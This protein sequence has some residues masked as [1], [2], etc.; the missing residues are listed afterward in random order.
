[1]NNSPLGRR[2]FLKLLGGALGL[3]G[4]SYYLGLNSRFEPP[5]PNP[6]P[7]YLDAGLAFPAFRGPYLQQEARLTALLFEADPSALDTL[8]AQT[9]NAVSNAPF[10]YRPILSGVLLV[11]AEM[12]VGSLDERDA[13][14]GLIPEREAGFWM[15]TV[16]MQKTALGPVPHHLAWHIPYLLVDES[17]AIATGREVY[18]FNKQAATFTPNSSSQTPGVSVEVLGFERFGPTAIAQKEHLLTV[19][20][21]GLAAR[22]SDWANWSEAQAE[23]RNALPARLRNDLED[24]LLAFAAQAALQ[25][26][27]LVFLKQFRDAGQTRQAC[28][29]QVVEA[30]IELRTFRGGGFFDQPAGMTLRGL[31]SHPLAR[32]LGLQASQTSTLGAWLDVDFVLGAGTTESAP[33]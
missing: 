21:P 20:L 26:I 30:P 12:L 24:G 9:V 3:G 10:E 28:F 17:N 22:G 29:Q 18:G 5:A 2:S 14:V 4:L 1:M 25:D 11:Y 15:L 27:P 16:A 19:T 8:C 31:D 23:V 7:A 32:L 6:M 33:K 13:Q